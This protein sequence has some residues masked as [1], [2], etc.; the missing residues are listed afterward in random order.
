MNNNHAT[1]DE[2]RIANTK[3]TIQLEAVTEQA[4]SLQE[5]LRSTTERMSLMEE[6]FN[7]FKDN[8]KTVKGGWLVIAYSGP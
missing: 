2:L 3:L 6:E 7:S 1:I 5:H 8:I 4:T